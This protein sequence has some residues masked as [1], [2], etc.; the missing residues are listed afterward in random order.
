MQKSVWLPNI[1][2][3]LTPYRL[4]TI[5]IS[6]LEGK[7]IKQMLKTKFQKIIFVWENKKP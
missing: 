1:Q 7:N 6:K 4:L 2:N 5:N 3:P